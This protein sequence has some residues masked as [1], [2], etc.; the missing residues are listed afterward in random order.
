MQRPSRARLHVSF[1]RG[2]YLSPPERGE[3]GLLPFRPPSSIFDHAL[4]INHSLLKTP[5]TFLS[6]FDRFLFFI[7]LIAGVD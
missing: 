3:F 4:K 5:T 6:L 1:F 7:I 2:Q